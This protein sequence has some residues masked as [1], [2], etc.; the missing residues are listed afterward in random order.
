M[1]TYI[2]WD[3]RPCSSMKGNRYFRRTYCLQ[4]QG[5]KVSHARNQHKAAVAATTTAT[6]NLRSLTQ[7][8]FQIIFFQE[9]HDLIR[10][11]F[12]LIADVGMHF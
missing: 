12:L 3:I 2:F 1:E 6:T 4:L 8:V 10:L 7:S 9:R 11:M 5:R